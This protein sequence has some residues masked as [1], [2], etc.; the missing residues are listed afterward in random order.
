MNVVFTKSFTLKRNSA[1]RMNLRLVSDPFSTEADEDIASS[2][3][4][5]AILSLADGFSE[6]VIS[7][8]V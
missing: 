2:G 7:L 5:D 8:V 1:V 3:T 4:D 6:T